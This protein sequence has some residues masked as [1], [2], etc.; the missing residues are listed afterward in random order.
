MISLRRAV[1]FVLSIDAAENIVFGRPLDIIANEQI[2]QSVAIEI[3]PQRRC[4]EG[5]PATQSGLFSDVDK[6]ALAGVL[7]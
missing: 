6:C 2:E 7:K 4:A 3:E 1:G 5:A